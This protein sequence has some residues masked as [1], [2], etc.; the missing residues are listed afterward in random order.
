MLCMKSVY[1]DIILMGEPSWWS[2][3]DDDVTISPENVAYFFPD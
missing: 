3:T 2:K 1:N